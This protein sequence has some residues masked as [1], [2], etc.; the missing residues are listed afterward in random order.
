[1]IKSEFGDRVLREDGFYNLLLNGRQIGFSLDIR[2]NYFRGLPLSCVKQLEVSVDGEEI[3]QYLILFELN[4]KQF[5]ISQFPQLYAEFWGLKTPASLKV[6]NYGLNAGMHDV[7]V[8]MIY[9]NPSAAP[10]TDEQI[11]GSASRRMTIGK[12]RVM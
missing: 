8:K 7:A 4:G 1:M 11:D 12:G 6:F 10:G 3:P 5:S 2:L 9:Q